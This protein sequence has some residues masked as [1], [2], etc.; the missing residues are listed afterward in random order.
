MMG[1]A[2]SWDY[3]VVWI[4]IREEKD[5]EEKNFKMFMALAMST[6]VAM[7]GVTSSIGSLQVQAAETRTT[8]NTPTT[9]RA[10]SIHVVKVMLDDRG[11]ALTFSRAP[12]PWP[13]DHFRET[14]ESLPEGFAPL[15]HL[16]LYAYRAGFLRRF[17]TLPQAP[18]EKLESLEQ[19]RALYYGE[20]IAVMVLDAALPAGVDT[21]KDL[22]RVRAIFEKSA[23]V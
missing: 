9:S 7:G 1:S 8:V 21:Q 10:S 11:T 19:L 12:I 17:P 23:P 4:H 22:D 18:L 5:N 16:G 2:Y 15:H 14:K 3:F 20:R 6:I 13:R